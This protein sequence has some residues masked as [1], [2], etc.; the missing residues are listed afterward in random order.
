MH[1]F[2]PIQRSRLE[3]IRWKIVFLCNNSYGGGACER[4]TPMTSLWC[5]VCCQR[6][7]SPPTLT[8]GLARPLIGRFANKNR[9]SS[10][11]KNRNV[12]VGF[13]KD[14]DDRHAAAAGTSS[15]SG[16]TLVAGQRQ[17]ATE[18]DE[19]QPARGYGF[20]YAVLDEYAGTDFGQWERREPGRDGA[21]TGQYRVRLPD[22]RTQTVRYT[23]D[24]DTG[25]MATVTYEGVQHH[26]P[27]P[28]D[29]PYDTAAA[30]EI[31][32]SSG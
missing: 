22:G 2:G 16:E 30:V 31:V 32:P 4:L 26:P 8:G 12:L 10:V 9:I 28:P 29:G 14:Y 6:S 3:Y 20:G 18:A 19:K 21:V 11:H 23:V 24:S 7:L 5:T 27:P 13:F 25:Y 17:T 1:P 15:P